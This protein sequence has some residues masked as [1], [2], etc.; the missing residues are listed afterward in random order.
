MDMSL[1]GFLN[2]RSSAIFCVCFADSVIKMLNNLKQTL[3]SWVFFLLT[4]NP[5]NTYVVPKAL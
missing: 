5:V 2:I 3:N 1:T 4:T